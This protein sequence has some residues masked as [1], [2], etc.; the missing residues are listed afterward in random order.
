MSHLLVKEPFITAG[1]RVLRIAKVEKQCVRCQYI[2]FK[3]TVTLT[4]KLQ[5]TKLTGKQRTKTG[6]MNDFELKL[7][8]AALLKIKPD[9]LRVIVAVDVFHDSGILK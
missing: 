3:P 2:I 6:V 4:I 8:F 5:I 1:Y 9:H 7:Q